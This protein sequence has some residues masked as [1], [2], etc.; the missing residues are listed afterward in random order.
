MLQER[1]AKVKR[2]QENAAA[3][4]AGAA[5]LAALAQ[6]RKQRLMK[7]EAPKPGKEREIPDT[8]V[9]TYFWPKPVAKI[10]NELPFRESQRRYGT[11]YRYLAPAD[12]FRGQYNP[13]YDLH[14]MTEKDQ[15]ITLKRD[16]L[17]MSANYRNKLLSETMNKRHRRLAKPSAV[18]GGMPWSGEPAPNER[19]VVARLRELVEDAM[20][21]VGGTMTDKPLLNAAANAT[22]ALDRRNGKEHHRTIMSFRILEDLMLERVLHPTA[23]ESRAMSEDGKTYAK[24]MIEFHTIQV[25]QTVIDCMTYMKG[26]TPDMAQLAAKQGPPAILACFLRYGGFVTQAGA[27]ATVAN[28]AKLLELAVGVGQYT[29]AFLLPLIETDVPEL[30][31]LAALVAINMLSTWKGNQQKIVDCNGLMIVGTTLT[32]RI[33]GTCAM[34]HERATLTMMALCDDEKIRLKAFHAGLPALMLL[35][36]NEGMTPCAIEAACYCITMLVLLED[37]QIFRACVEPVSAMMRSKLP[38][39]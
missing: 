26:V 14:R 36:L 38:K 1:K 15:L 22:V 19:E 20:G 30:R 37:R 10:P 12:P 28:C 31:Q 29:I 16:M 8:T 39:A 11:E 9:Y 13:E 18:A 21:H 35:N 4:G 23:K 25:P 33:G 7:M 17:Q 27:A 34:V 6:E 32:D 24:T 2:A 5:K 3:K